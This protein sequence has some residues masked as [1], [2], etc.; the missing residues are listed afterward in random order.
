MK[1][2]IC[3]GNLIK[4]VSFVTSKRTILIC[5]KC[6][7]HFLSNNQGQLLSNLN[8]DP[9]IEN[10]AH[11]KSASEDLN[12]FDEARKSSVYKKFLTIE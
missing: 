11:S 12:R 10:D 7:V 9:I 4:K 1:C 5:N 2:Q 6:G 3:M 8:G